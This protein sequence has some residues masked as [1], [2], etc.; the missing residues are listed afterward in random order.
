[1]DSP[2]S[3]AGKHGNRQ[4]GNH[5][6]VD[7]HAIA[8]L[9]AEIDQ[10]VRKAADALKKFGVR[11]F[12]RRA[13]FGLPEDRGLV[14][15]SLRVPVEAV[16]GDVELAADEPLRMRQL[17]FEHLRVGLEPVEHLGLL[18]PEALRIER[19]VFVHFAIFFE[20]F[21]VGAL[22][23]FFRRRDRL[24]IENVGIELQHCSSSRR[25]PPGRPLGRERNLLAGQY[26]IGARGIGQG[27]LAGR[28][29]R[30]WTLLLWLTGWLAERSSCS[31]SPPSP[32]ATGY[33]A[34]AFARLRERRLG[35][36]PRLNLCVK[37]RQGIL[38]SGTKGAACGNTY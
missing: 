9:H 15:L 11:E 34:A 22:A 2:D 16:V 27:W 18:A 7:C 20:R 35:P 36:Q 1:M 30:N 19:G 23:E 28:L 29:A 12:E 5:R 38:I 31:R 25:L 17:P 3:R 14:R 21:Y 4:L 37:Y 24:L 8:G 6:Q 10:R 32:G 13:V 33:G 26:V